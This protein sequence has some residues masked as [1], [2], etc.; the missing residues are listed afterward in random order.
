MNKLELIIFDCDGILVDSEP[1]SN[2]VI[3]EEISALGIPTNTGEAIN[4]FAGGSLQNVEDYIVEKIGKPI[5]YDFEKKY[6][7]RTAELFKKELK[8]VEGIEDVLK[9]ISLPMCVASNGPKEKI[10]LNLNITQLSGYF[11]GNLFS[12]YDI[13]AWKPDPALYLHAGNE[14]NVE[15]ASCLVIEDSLHGVQA[16]VSAGMKVLGYTAHIE[17]SKMLNAGAI[18]FDAMSNLIPLLNKVASTF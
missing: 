3:A 18:P 1:L 12:A 8:Q 2:Q 7:K 16:A 10:V 4:L 13:N 9:K 5:P 11:N 15:P 14:M 6:R 17:E